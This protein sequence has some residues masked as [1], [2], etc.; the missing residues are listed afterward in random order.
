MYTEKDWVRLKVRH[1]PFLGQEFRTGITVKRVIPVRNSHPCVAVS[2]AYH[3]GGGD[4]ET[5]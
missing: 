3:K 4:I 1:Y 2:I 5:G